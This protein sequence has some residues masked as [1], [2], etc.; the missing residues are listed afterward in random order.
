MAFQAPILRTIAAFLESL[1]IPVR[2]TRITHKT[3]VLGVDI[4]EGGLIV[5]EPQLVSPADPL[6]EGGHLAI[7]PRALRRDL[8][9]TINSTPAQEVSVLAWQ[10]AAALHIGIPTE[11]MFHE[12]CVGGMGPTLL[13]NFR[14]GR[15]VGV[16][17]LRKWGMT[18]D[19]P[20][21]LR[22]TID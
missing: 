20:R 6:H 16:P 5:D 17:M 8:Y 10:W 19:Y 4:H 18:V 9:G 13:E 2:P 12:Q 21:M 22:W 3:L 7:T 14:E 1:D 15:Y 11:A